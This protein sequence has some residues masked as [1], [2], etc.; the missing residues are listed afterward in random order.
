M[1]NFLKY[2]S[3]IALLGFMSVSCSDWLAPER[4]IVQ[5]PDEQSSVLRDDAYYQAL[6]E[7]KKTKHRIAFGWYGSWTAV[8]ASYQ[9]RLESAPDSMD[10]ISIW[11]QW[12]TLT[13]EQRADMEKVQ[14]LKGTKVTFTIFSDVLPKAFIPDCTDYDTDKYDES[15]YTDE[16][17]AA[18]AKAYCRDSIDKYNYDGIDI[19]YE[20]GY[21]AHG[22]FV[23][24]NNPLMTKLI[25]EMSKYVGP[26]S[27]TGRLF[28]IDGVPHAVDPSVVDCFDYG[29]SQAYASGGYSDLQNRFNSAY[30]D[31]WKPE[32]FIFAENFESYWKDGGVN[33]RCR[34]GQ[35]VNSLKGMARFNPTQGFL[36]GFGAYHM[37]YEYARSEKPYKYMREAIQDVNPAGG[38]IKLSLA[39]GQTSI[40]SLMLESDGSITGEMADSMQLTLSRPADQA[41]KFDVSIN[42]ELI[43]AYNKENHTEFI[44]IDHN[45]V[46]I[47]ELAFEPDNFNSGKCGVT[48]NT[49]G[50]EKGFYM[51]P[52][53]VAVPEE[54][55]ITNGP[56][57]HYV[58]VK[59]VATDIQVGATEV[60][61]TMITPTEDWDFHCY[62]R[63]SSSG[64]TGVWNCDSDAQRKKMF[65][66]KRDSGAWYTNG[67]SWA[68]GRGG[69]FIIQMDK[70]YDVTGFRWSIYYDDAQPEILD[71]MYSEDGVVW[72]DIAYGVPFT[73]VLTDQ[74]W[75]IFQFK[76]TVKAR[77]LRV[78]VAPI[79]GWGFTSMNECEIYGPAK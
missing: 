79:S 23:G 1:K 59:I 12:H 66:G 73:P 76:K 75:K 67:A 50:L 62:Q 49:D 63:T 17:I 45:R 78:F 60:T 39:T 13:P 31:G 53:V 38:A 74:A 42:D 26:K 43:E 55:F 32:Q 28:L 3:V 21:G 22:P 51:I 64:A 37:E 44:A 29:I 5:H 8:G 61:G 54:G 15:K 24:H 20:P 33:H 11:S 2:I 14:K 19:D 25:Q 10:I 69:N 71:V 30:Q 68:W 6:R 34:D 48:V 72:K 56:I 7:Y 70:I 27:G 36:G 77:Y 18:Y 52:V 65:D 35:Y 58:G 57:V 4:V 9:T 40:Y 47:D 41:Y 46:K 16:A